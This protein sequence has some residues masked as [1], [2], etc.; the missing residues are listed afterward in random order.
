MAVLVLS[1]Y[2]KLLAGH[3]EAALPC[4][5]P[6]CSSRRVNVVYLHASLEA[7]AGEI[8]QEKALEAMTLLHGEVSS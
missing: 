7:C 2:L 5:M 3:S 6:A 1:P 8:H 4:S